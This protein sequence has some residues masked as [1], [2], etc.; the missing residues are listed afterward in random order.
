ME[1]QSA[2]EPT[3]DHNTTVNSESASG[4]IISTVAL[5]ARLRS[6]RRCSRRIRPRRDIESLRTVTESWG[7]DR[8]Q[9]SLT[10]GSISTLT[11]VVDG[12]S[13]WYTVSEVTA[14]EEL[15]SV[16]VVLRSLAYA[17]GGSSEVNPRVRAVHPVSFTGNPWGTSDQS[18]D[19][20][21]ASR[22]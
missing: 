12:R 18:S 21:V 9:Y 11:T 3:V 1:T 6:D 17:G 19:E 22:L 7:P 2:W 14:N 15:V 13:N 8:N 4:G 10:I 16:S 5:P 20:A